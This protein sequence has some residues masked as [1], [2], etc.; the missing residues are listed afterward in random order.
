MLHTS[1]SI[2]VAVSAVIAVSAATSANT[3]IPASD[4]LARLAGY[5]TGNAVM[6]SIS[7]EPESFKCVVTYLPTSDGSGMKQ[8]LRCK[9]ESLKL[10]GAMLLQ[11]EGR[12]VTGSWEDRINSLTGNVQ[13]DVT[14]NGFDVML[15][16]PFF[17]AR[18]AVAGSDCAQQVKVSPRQS[19]YFVELSAALRKC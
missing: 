18:M 9:G 2:K 5:W 3:A 17:Q 12:K 7:G 15:G 16:G 19:S 4:P 1:R 10:E 14:E 13:G 8:N 11:I 6:T